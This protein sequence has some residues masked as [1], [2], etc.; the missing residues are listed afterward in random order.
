MTTYP[1]KILTPAGV[2]VSGDV[3]QIKVSTVDG[4]LGIMAKHAPMIVACPAGIIEICQD[5]EW[6]KF[7]TAQA[8]VTCDGAQV[9]ILTTHAIMAV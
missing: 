8:I 5:N 7:R 4:S 3:T 6:I 9:S 1:F 2:F